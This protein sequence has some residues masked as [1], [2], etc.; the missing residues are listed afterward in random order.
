MKKVIVL[1]GAGFIGINM[2]N[3][4][5]KK[6]Y[7][8]LSIDKMNYASNKK[9]KIFKKVRNLRIDIN[10]KKIKTI[11]KKFKPDYIL[12]FAA[13]THVDRSIDNADKFIKSNINGV[14]NILESIKNLN[15]KNKLKYIQ[16]STDEV[17]GSIKSKKKSKENDRYNPSSPYAAS[18]AAADMIIKS[19]IVTFNFPAIITNCCN[20]FGPFQYPEKFIPKSIMNT[21]NNQP[22]NIYGKGLNEREWIYVGD[23][24]L[25]LLEIMKRGKL[26]EQYNIGSGYVKNNTF[27]AKKI[28]K[29]FK[30]NKKKNIKFIKD[31]PAH[32]VRYA[33]N[34][35]K[36]KNVLKF[37]IS[38][39]FDQGL[40][41][42]IIW[43]KNS[44]WINKK[45]HKSFNQRLGL[46]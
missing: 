34:S 36:L 39:R 3:L 9:E 23:H 22:I 18:K 15:Y 35:N 24:C 12:N 17:Y 46:I 10:D 21:I 41:K 5:N 8:I 1:G 6:K 2:V 7:K 33:L 4:L 38:T 27:I 26:G 30:K 20:N 25:A 43:Y 14:F 11:F 37:K 45:K 31:R 16:I 42:T 44:K 29:Y 28:L 19:Y 32:D 40:R 13:E